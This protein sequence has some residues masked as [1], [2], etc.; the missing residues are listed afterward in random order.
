LYKLVYKIKGVEATAR[1]KD[2]KVLREMINCLDKD[3]SFWLYNEGGICLDSSDGSDFAYFKGL[4]K[5]GG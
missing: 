5:K 4:P 1:N 3:D 2:C